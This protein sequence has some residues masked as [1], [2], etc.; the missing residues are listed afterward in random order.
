MDGVMQNGVNQ[1]N[2]E[3]EVISIIGYQKCTSMLAKT[4]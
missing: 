4:I 3:K 1:H 2:V